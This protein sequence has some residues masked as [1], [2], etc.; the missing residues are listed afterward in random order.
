[1]DR[2]RKK[3]FPGAGLAEQ[4]YRH[5]RFRGEQRELQTARHRRIARCQVLNFELGKRQLHQIDYWAR[6]SRSCRTGSKAYSI[7]VRPPTMICASPLIPTRRA[8]FCP[9]APGMIVFSSEAKPTKCGPSVEL[10][11][12]G[13]IQSSFPFSAP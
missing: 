4:N 12:E 13:L 9:F 3:G 1:M 2:V 8:R 10:I 5:I 6:S 11:A 7:K